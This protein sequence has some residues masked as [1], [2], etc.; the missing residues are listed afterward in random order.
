M[1]DMV[2]AARKAKIKVVGSNPNLLAA[3]APVKLKP[4]T[5]YV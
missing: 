2:G 5:R 1:K 3:T 4:I